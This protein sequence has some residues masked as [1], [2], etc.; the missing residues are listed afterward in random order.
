MPPSPSP[1][2]SPSPPLPPAE[3]RLWELAWSLEQLA[4]R[5]EAEGKAEAAAVLIRAAEVV[6]AEGVPW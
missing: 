3:L 5:L 1:S 4:V 6:I 2:P